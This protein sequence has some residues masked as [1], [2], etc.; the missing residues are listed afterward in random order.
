MLQ[1][2]V[3]EASGRSANVETDFAVEIDAPVFE[4]LLQF[5]AAAADVAEIRPQQAHTGFAV[6]GCARFFDF[7]FVDQNFSGK[8]KRLG[9]LTR[10][11]ESTIHE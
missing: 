4:R 11:R 10:R 2:A 8:D 9:A 6:D 3:A 5:E 1:H 7:L